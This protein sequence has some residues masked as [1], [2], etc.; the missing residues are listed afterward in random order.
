MKKI[1]SAII[2]VVLV[3]SMLTVSAMADEEHELS[4][5]SAVVLCAD[6]GDVLFEKNADERMLIASI[7][8]I[9]TAIVVIENAD[10]DAE[11]V[12][13]PEWSAIEGSSMYANPGQSYTVRELLYG[14][15]L[16]SGNDAAAALACTLCGDEHS[17]AEKMN[18]KAA[19]LGL[20][21]T[22]FRNPHGL[23]DEE[24]YSTAR[25]MARLTA[26]CMENEEFKSIVSTNCAVIKG[27]TYYNHNRLLRE[28]EGCIGVK[29]GYTIAAGRTLVSCAERGGMR[30][31]CVTLS[32]PDDWNDHKYLLDKVFSDYRIASYSADS[33]K[34]TLEVSSAVASTAE[35]VPQNEIKLL[36]NADDDLDVR[37][38]APR[39]LFAGGI[40]GERVGR[41]SVFVNGALAAQEDLVYTEDVKVNSAQRL[42]PYERLVRIFDT[43]M[44]PYYIEGESK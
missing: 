25:D 33:F 26:Y 23:D 18:E 4:A 3:S 44:R 35:A 32:A 12:I 22:S 17:F 10:L 43:A 38:E 21:N 24:H 28:Y 9:M 11:I 14:M 2:T 6:T 40:E 37:L 41:I 31:I 20:E 19:E 1:I 13:K 7:T 29:T 8:K 5:Y 36:V 42:T 30:L 27:V 16:N 39:M 34:V 15:M